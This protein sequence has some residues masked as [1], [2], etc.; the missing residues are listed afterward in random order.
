MFISVS[1]ERSKPRTHQELSPFPIYF[2]H[3]PVLKLVILCMDHAELNA[4]QQ[5]SLSAGTVLSLKSLGY[6][7]KDL[8]SNV[9]LTSH[10]LS[11]PH[12]R[13]FLL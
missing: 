9:P 8:F 5:V 6:I 2:G 10:Y 7:P 1:Q 11:M 13:V 3:S 12:R 4:V